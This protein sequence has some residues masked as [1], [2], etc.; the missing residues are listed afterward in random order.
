LSERVRHQLFIQFFKETQFMFRI[1]ISG[2][3]L[4]VLVIAISINA[5]S[6]AR[7]V[8]YWPGNG[9]PDDI[10]DSNTA[11]TPGG[12][13][14]AA[15]MAGQAFSLDGFS[16]YV[17]VPD[18][19]SL[20]LTGPYTLSAWININTNSVQQAIIEKYDVPGHNGYGLR[21][22]AGK[23]TAFNCDSVTSDPWPDMLGSTTVSTGV[24]HHVASV[25]DGTRIKIYLDGILDADYP[26]TRVPTDGTTSLKIGARGDDANTRLNGLIDEVKIY[27]RALQPWD[28]ESLFSGV[29]VTPIP[30]STG[31]RAYVTNQGGVGTLKV[32]DLTTNSLLTSIPLGGIPNEVVLSPEGSRAYVTTYNLDRVWVIDTATN[33]V[34]A[35]IPTGPSPF[36]L[37]VKP[38]GSKIYVTNNGG[39]TVSVI[40]TVN[41]AVTATVTVG[42]NPVGVAFTP[43]GTWA[44]VTNITS[45]TVSVID[46]STDTVTASIFLGSFAPYGTILPW[47]ISITPD[48][49]RAVVTN[50]ANRSLTIIDTSTNTIETKISVGTD[51]FNPRYVGFSPT[52]DLAYV[53]VEGG[54]TVRVV[55]LTTLTEITSIYEG[56]SPF[57][58]AVSANGSRIYVA[59]YNSGFSVVDTTTRSVVANIPMP[60]GTFHV[61]LWE[62]VT[63]DSTPPNIQPTI[64]GTIGN[65]GWYVDDVEVSW[66][67]TDPESSISSSTGCNNSTFTAD[68][69]GIT[70][71]CSATSGGGTEI[72]SV[73]IKRDAT[74]PG[75]SCGLA[76]ATW[77]VS[78]VSIGC[79]ASDGISGLVNSSDAGFELTTAVAPGTE[80]ANA[81]TGTRQVCDTA[82]NC[83]TA[84]PVSGNKIDKKAPAIRIIAPTSGTY[85]LNQAVTVDYDCSDGGSGVASCS[86]TVAN[87][88]QVNTATA[89]NHTFTVSSADNVGNTASSLTV[90]YVVKFGLVVLFDQTKASK[91][92]S[93]V[94]IKV[95]LVDS[96]GSNV[97][98]IGTVLHATSVIQTSSLASTVL[99]NAGSSNPDFDFRYDA[100]LGGYIF[101]LQTS[102]YETGTYI[103]NFAAAG[104][105]AVYTVGFQVRQ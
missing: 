92:G 70:V 11:T 46:T 8:S 75:I 68:A 17:Q 101:N 28:I 76:D 45:D 64:T 89:G 72:Q 69:T 27:N 98:A 19:P 40:S 67:V 57:G 83:S 54:G 63:T 60:Q 102:G 1:L 38:D 62:A 15:G 103:L 58:L 93:T 33:S 6:Q 77:H 7:L 87:G 20:S 29:A 37:K 50:V 3:S 51:G 71:T 39:N 25:Y 5:Y 55:D 21:I 65:N 14:Y 79:T 13:V 105:S 42:A 10:A 84:G 34:I 24:W 4:V 44:Y 96:N 53:S 59:N 22:Y 52:G 26:A 86:G 61:A 90:N 80:T 43:D 78:D 9:S 82:G 31:S 91:S 74:G 16:R 66:S 99:D 97:S 30:P 95:R 36:G 94:P 2:L 41:N 18:S 73:T 35:G 12:A 49:N 85:L 32:V 47:G 81:S 88:G 104:G 23:L 48:G 100:G 56:T